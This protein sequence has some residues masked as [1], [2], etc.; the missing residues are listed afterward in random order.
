[1]PAANA[2]AAAALADD[3]AALASVE[4]GA[5]A[6]TTAPPA[7]PAV[8]PATPAEPEPEEIEETDEVEEAE[9]EQPTMEVKVA[10]TLADLQAS[11]SGT[12]TA[13]ML[14]RTLV[15]K[16]PTFSESDYGFRSFGEF[17]RF[18]ADRGFV[19]LAGGPSTGDPE[20]AL[21]EQQDTGGAF[22]LLRTVVRDAGGSA[23]LSGLKNEVRK[24]RPDFS[25][26][27]L[28][29]RGFL[30][31]AKGAQA[32]GAVALGWAYDADDYVVTVG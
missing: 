14:K 16:D 23:P 9:G 11:S 27:T 20:V 7:A 22:D 1:V 12:V 29:Y 26:K 25:E 8:E 21:P 17:L 4:K 10:Q 2:A 6:D 3:F 15:R 30:Q 18:L 5:E 13:S 28:G 19:V 31:F 24:R 32:A